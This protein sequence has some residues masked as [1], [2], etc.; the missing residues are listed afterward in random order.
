MHQQQH[1]TKQQ[2]EADKIVAL[3]K[4]NRPQWNPESQ[5]Q[6]DQDRAGCELQKQPRSTDE[7]A[8]RGDFFSSALPSNFTEK[9]SRN[10]QNPQDAVQRA[11]YRA[12]RGPCCSES[13]MHDL[14]SA[15]M[16]VAY[17]GAVG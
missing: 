3:K 4:S 16:R 1:D 6:H 12:R 14:T 5:E 17:R 11:D 8:R 2:Q 15:R 10:Q 9:W 13:Q 7:S